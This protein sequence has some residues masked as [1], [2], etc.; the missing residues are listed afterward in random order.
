MA[1]AFNP[2]TQEAETV[3][4]CEFKA[5]LVY[6]ASYIVRPCLKP[7]S[8][9]L[10]NKVMIFKNMNPRKGNGS[11]SK[12]LTKPDH[13]RPSPKIYVGGREHGFP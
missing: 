5:S 4:L 11:V 2:S 12:D 8:K 13:L 7:N 9:A 3:E 1:H 10:D 6:I